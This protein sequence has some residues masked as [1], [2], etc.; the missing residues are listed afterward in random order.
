MGKGKSSEA[1]GKMIQDLQGKGFMIF[2]CNQ[3][4]EQAI[5]A[6]CKLGIDFIAFPIGNF[7]QIIHA[8]NYALR[9]GIAFGGI[10]PESVRIPA[11][12]SVAVCAPLCCS[13]AK[14]MKSRLLPTLPP[15]S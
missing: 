2:L 4:I 10:P 11:T 7:T 6:G 13:W 5:E 3:V 1:V 8:V 12:T 9:A 15:S 14:L